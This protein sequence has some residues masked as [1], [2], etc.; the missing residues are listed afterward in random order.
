MARKIRN[1][2]GRRWQTRIAKTVCAIPS[3]NVAAP[4]SIASP[5]NFLERTFG[6]LDVLIDN[7]GIINL[8][9]NHENK[10]SRFQRVSE[11]GRVKTRYARFSRSW[12]IG[13]HF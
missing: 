7:A 13:V 9:R 5:A 10:Q 4:E 1:R 8:S 6:H 11:R 2:P 3:L 12:K